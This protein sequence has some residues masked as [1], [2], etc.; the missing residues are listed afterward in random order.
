[1]GQAA[2]REPLI[3]IIIGIHLYYKIKAVHYADTSTLLK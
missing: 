2:S 3:I 1:M